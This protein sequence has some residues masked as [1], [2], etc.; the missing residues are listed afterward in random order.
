V[1]VLG[2]VMVTVDD[3]PV[4]LSR[5]LEKALLARLSLSPGNDI[6]QTRLIDDLWGDRPPSNA[7]GSLHTLV[8]RLRR[9]LGPAASAIDWTGH[10]YR[11]ALPAECVDATK[12][13][14]LVA[15]AKQS[16]GAM[17]P[18][19][20]ALLREALGLW[21]GPAL[22]G[23]DS[24]PFVKPHRAALEA[25][26][27]RALAERIEADLADGAGPE[28]V[29][30]LEGLV[31]EHP[32]DEKLWG[33]LIVALYRSGSQAAALR[34]YE[35]VRRL[36]SDELGIPPSPP[37]VE[38]ERAILM[39]DP[40]LLAG[41]RPRAPASSPR[42]S[43]E[44]AVGQDVVTIVAT[45]LASR[46]RL[47]A[48]FPSE[49]AN[50]MQRY[51]ELLVATV[52]THGGRLLSR[53]DG[54][55][56]SAFTRPSDALGAAFHLRT[57]VST[58]V[59]G[60]I[61]TLPVTAAVHTGEAEIVEDNVFGPVLHSASRLARAAYAGQV[62]IS[63]TTAELVRD[64]LP[65]GCE[66]LDL[67]YWSLSDVPR[68]L[69]AYEL[70]H[71]D[72]GS[73]VRALRAGRPGTGT[74]PMPSTSF[75]GRDAELDELVELLEESPIVTLT[76]VGGVGKTR[77]ALHCGAAQ[78]SR[79]PGGAW[80][81]DLSAATTPDEVIERLASALGVHGASTQ[82]LRRDVSDWLRFSQSLLI[83]D[84]CE[85]VAGTVATE[86]G[87]VLADG[88]LSKVMFTSRRPLRLPGEHVLR[89]NPLR[90][91]TAPPDTNPVEP[92]VVL[93]VQRAR[94]AGAL[95]DPH[96]PALLEIVDRLDGLPLAIELAARRL[97]TMTPRELKVRLDRS[98][99]LLDLAD[100]SRPG[101]ALRATIDWSFGLLSPTARRMF[102][103]LSVCEGRFGLELAGA[104]GAALDLTDT[105]VANAIADLWDQSLIGTDKWVPGR[106]RYWMLAVLRDYA[107]TQ[108][109]VDG[110][111][112]KVAGAHAAYYTALMARWAKTPYG[113]QESES[114]DI[115]DL[116]SDNIR[117]AFAWCVAERS[118]D[119]AMELLDCAI[120]EL[121]LRERIEIG[122][123][124]AE[125][126][127]TLGE[128]LHPVRSVAL[129]IAA[130]T[131]L[132]EGRLDDAERLGRQS[133]ELEVLL[134]APISWLSRNVLA[135]VCA[136]GSQFEESETLLDELVQITA[137]TGDPM[138]HAV[139]CFDRA[140]IASFSS[141][142]AAGLGPAEEL[143]ALGESWGS[144]SLRAMGL[145]SVGRVLATDDPARARRAL[146]EA[147][148]LAHASRS[149]LLAGQSQR[150]LTEI[151][152][153][154][155]DH[156]AGLA[157]LGDLLR[158]FGRSGDLSQQ[159]QTVVSTL[160]SL[161]AVDAFELATLLCGAL[162]Q[163]ALGSAAQCERVLA[164]SRT[165]LS[166]EAYRTAFRRG[167]QLSPTELMQVA[168]AEI[169]RL[170]TH[171]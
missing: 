132:V 18:P 125:T 71:R 133:L 25:T 87:P 43:R 61:G 73:A 161:I 153:A 50:A 21:R 36:L 146:G 139:A 37:L 126:L 165:R 94:S 83:V 107:S 59:W 116:A 160:D 12:F 112:T 93:L 129:A 49:M 30:E 158:G 99:D 60:A 51:D 2:S 88:V 63:A 64:G 55:S 118:W 32:F 170:T 135:L 108:L 10:G 81:C 150:V 46:A 85:H 68:P 92:S 31:T 72:L 90:R 157:A 74:L 101:R 82:E 113:P 58:E 124:A 148:D 105:E 89:I 143:V 145:V 96:D 57:S 154:S 26:R 4:A 84:N 97:T 137:V 140:L 151:D 104:I 23:L 6:G 53:A 147:V 45:D 122:R 171:A 8:Y 52:G 20:R 110:N 155:G 149:S 114:V 39:Q 15:R 9:S 41:E 5:T 128:S 28:L 79:F 134:D 100:G 11:L 166:G 121:I 162:G 56:F 40:S 65:P 95:I 69:H 42:R 98:F 66:L 35:R 38:L 91:S 1:G 48:E 141:S 14:L 109:D 24:I 22:A 103:A 67:G 159:L 169:T 131:A 123:W 130:N 44:A 16:P 144:A 136:S 62:V 138:P 17:A 127:S 164:V 142:P 70:R 34:C 117:A 86:L 102:A 167:A 75:L 3:S 106:A 119:L 29:A 152:A 156:F 163:T 27:L 47:W 78:S 111:R 168:A 80:F 33:H 19:Q 13:S 115:I 120:P 7:V 76:G 54:S 77:L